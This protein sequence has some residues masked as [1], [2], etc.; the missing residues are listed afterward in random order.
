MLK[1]QHEKQHSGMR[2]AEKQHGNTGKLEAGQAGTQAA[3]V[4]RGSRQARPRQRQGERPRQVALPKIETTRG[5]PG[6]AGRPLVVQ[7]G[8]ALHNPHGRRGASGSSPWRKNA[9]VSISRLSELAELRF[10]PLRARDRCSA[11]PETGGRPSPRARRVADPR[12][13]RLG[14]PLLDPVPGRVAQVERVADAGSRPTRAAARGSRRHGAAR[15][16][17]GRSRAG[18]RERAPAPRTSPRRRSTPSGALTAKRNP[19]GTWAA[20]ERNCSSDGSRYFVAFSSTASRLL[21]VVGEERPRGRVP[22]G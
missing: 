5:R 10:D 22:A 13:P 4:E 16:R 3:T 6:S 12:R 19:S 17:C 2:H 11:A 14:E 9:N 18:R 20:H 21:R 8:A 15:R 7:T 1:Q